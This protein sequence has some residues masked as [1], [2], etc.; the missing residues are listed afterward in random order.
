MT[1]GGGCCQAGG[2][3]RGGVLMRLT[4]KL[5]LMAAKQAASST[6]GA[7]ETVDLYPDLTG[8]NPAPGL[9]TGPDDLYCGIRLFGRA[10]TYYVRAGLRAEGPVL[11]RLMLV[12][13]AGAPIETADLRRVPVSRLA[14]IAAS[15]HVNEGDD[16]GPEVDLSALKA[17]EVRTSP[18]GARRGGRKPRSDDELREVAEIVQRERRYGR[19]ARKAVAKHLDRTETTADKVIRQAREAGFLEPL[20]PP[21]ARQ[22]ETREGGLQ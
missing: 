6:P 2:D 22:K 21:P 9:V 15:I 5:A 11:L 4:D 18:E 13:D 19:S 8:E 14:T 20:K 17:V 10:I 7:V 12:P 3:A 1:G 16:N